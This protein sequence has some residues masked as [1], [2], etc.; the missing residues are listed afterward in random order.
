MDELFQGLK[1]SGTD[2][3]MMDQVGSLGQAD[4]VDAG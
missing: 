1:L 2:A 3:P 4:L